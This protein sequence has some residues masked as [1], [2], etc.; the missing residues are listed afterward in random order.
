[1]FEIGKIPPEI[2]ER[3]VL[4]PLNSN[5]LKRTDVV[6]RPKTGEDCAAVDLGGELL[7]VSTD[8]ITGAQKDM[9]YIAV[10][11]NCNDIAA[12]G[13]EP[14]GIL[15]TALLP[16]GSG[17]ETLK[18]I[19]D[20]AQRAA[21]E[22]GIEILGGHTEVTDA[23]NKPLLSAA[24]IGKSRNRQLVT[25]GGA[26]EGLDIVM[27][28]WAGLEGT[29]IIANDYQEELKKLVPANYLERAAT[30]AGFLSVVPEANIAVE[31]GAYAMHDATEGG[32]FGAVWEMADCSGVGVCLNADKIP[33]KE[34]TKAICQAA[35]I[36]P[37]GLISS[38]TLLIAVKNGEGLV[39]QLGEAEIDGAVIGQFTRGEKAL[40]KNGRIQTLEQ[41]KS[42]ELYRVKINKVQ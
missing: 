21:R 23:V 1:M 15:L 42:D 17:E 9:G 40:I 4:D 28:K 3:I 26:L 33:V 13:A 27:T 10:H 38:G 12:T 20:G 41:P 34:E 14:V 5:P 31:Y 35:G 25:T 16:A 19:M 18:D 7:V 22:L 32:I 8:P 30:Y 29:H 39:K 6:L 11:I 37:Y 24:V 36:D 2:L